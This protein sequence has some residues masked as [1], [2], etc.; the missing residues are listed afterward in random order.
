MGGMSELP[1][2][3]FVNR[4]TGGVTICVLALGDRERNFQAL[5]ECILQFACEPKLIST[6]SLSSNPCII[7]AT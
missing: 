6:N 5:V 1:D 4:G 2:C 3:C 7:I